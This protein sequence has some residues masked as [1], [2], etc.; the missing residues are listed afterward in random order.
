MTAMAVA[1]TAIP[2]VA[3]GVRAGAAVIRSGRIMRGGASAVRA[4][5]TGSILRVAMTGDGTTTGMTI[6][7]EVRAVISVAE[8]TLFAPGFLLPWQGVKPA[9][10][11][12]Y[13]QA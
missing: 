4:I 6:A 12:L 11:A 13:Q 3:G 5:A 9:V 8:I 7:A 2:V 1:I 10:P